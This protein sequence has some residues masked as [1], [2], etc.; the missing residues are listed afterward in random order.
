MKYYQLGHSGLIVSELAM[1]AMTFGSG[2]YYGFKYTVGQ[3]EANDM[4]AKATEKGI[5]FFDTAV[6][7]ANGESEII[8][9]KALGK[10]RKDNLIATKIA[11]RAGE[12]PFRAG[13]SLKNLVECTNESLI[14]LNTDYID[15]LL[16]HNDD[17]LTPVE[18][19]ARTMETLVQSGKVRYIGLSNFP[20]WK[21]ATLVQLQKALG[22]H[23]LVASQ[24]HYSLLN[25]EVEQEFVPMSLYHGLGMMVWSPLSSGFLTGKYTRE[26]PAPQDSRLNSFDLGLFDR[27]KGYDVVDK[28]KEIARA[29]QSS[30]IAVS[31]AWLLTKSVVSTVIVG[32][33][34]IG[35]LDDNLA[36]A[37]LTLTPDEIKAL[38][39]LT[40]PPVRYPNTFINAQDSVLKAARKFGK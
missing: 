26:N 40:Q 29:H 31:I 17:P 1:G 7:Y 14:R 4:I 33:S 22:Y 6:S 18:E 34:R 24:M 23:P 32:A 38:D 10:K 36:A 3:Q 37:D 21:A 15:V 5:N 8:L 13:I 16:L 12:P 39:E 9:G 20:A 27:E 11:F 2:D 25:R 19:V 30:P 35:Q 28:V